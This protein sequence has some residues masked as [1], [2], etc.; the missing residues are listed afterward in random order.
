LAFPHPVIPHDGPRASGAPLLDA[1]CYRFSL[2][3]MM[4][5]FPLAPLLTTPLERIVVMIPPVPPDVW[6][7]ADFQVPKDYYS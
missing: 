2:V 4:T 5:P 6:R 7:V 3:M 1:K